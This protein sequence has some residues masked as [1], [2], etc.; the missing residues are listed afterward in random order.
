[1]WVFVQLGTHLE[2]SA[3]ELLWAASR[4]SYSINPLVVSPCI[5]GA[6]SSSSKLP[7]FDSK[8]VLKLARLGIYYAVTCF[9]TDTVLLVASSFIGAT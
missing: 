5:V 7:G 3:V 4:S 2:D 1:M 6:C 8:G 9:G